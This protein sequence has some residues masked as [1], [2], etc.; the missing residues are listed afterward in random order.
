MSYT[1][2][3]RQNIEKSKR[4]ARQRGASPRVT[5]ALL[6]AEGVE[7]NYKNLN[8]GDRDSQG[9]LQQRPSQGWGQPG[10]V[11]QDV[12]DFLDRALKLNRGFHGSAGQ[13]AQGVQRSAFP[14]RYDKQN[15]AGLLGGSG[16]AV[17]SHS[18][19]QVT[20]K[21]TTPG[22]DNS[23]LRRQLRAQYLLQRDQ[24]GALAML[25]QGLANAKD[26]PSTVSYKTTGAKA[27]IG[28]AKVDQFKAAA[29]LLN[30]AHNPY[31][32]GGGHGK[33]L[34]LL[35]G[36]KPVPVDCSGA[37]SAV[38]GINPRVAA[39]FKSWGKAGHGKSV[40][41]WA[42][43][44]G[45]HVL[46]EINGHFFGTSGSNPGGGAGWIPRSKISKSYLSRFVARHPAGL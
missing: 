25:V 5:K 35:K 6:Q 37:V 28:G 2:E 29:D 23:A 11:E 39:E 44:D 4:I 24:P 20:T 40:T 9:I 27:I 14:D 26:S 13:L 12:N 7:S 38:L 33:N 34:K 42:A 16:A 19:G 46:M 36:G 8:Y 22:V 43:K 15:V 30:A 41:V 31:K 45:S 18:T 17:P 32:W 1:P 3:Q 10:S 21:T